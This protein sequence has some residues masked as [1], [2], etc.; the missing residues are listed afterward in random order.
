MS[1]SGIRSYFRSKLTTVDS[2]LHEWTDGFNIENIPETIIDKAWHLTFESTA[3]QSINQNCFYIEYPVILNVFLLSGIDVAS[4]I[5]SANVLGQ[6][7]YQE[8]LK[9]TSRL[10]ITGTSAAKIINIIPGPMSINQFSPDN[11]NTIRLQIN[12][13]FQIYLELS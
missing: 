3:P 7:I 10:N 12:F 9:H 5:D 8:I 13:T 11:D 6:S 4:G 2:D 1:F